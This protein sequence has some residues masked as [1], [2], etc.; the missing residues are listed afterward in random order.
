MWKQNLLHAIAI[1]CAPSGSSPS[2]PSRT[3]S[4]FSSD[5]IVQLA[6]LEDAPAGNFDR[7]LTSVLDDLERVGILFFYNSQNESTQMDTMLVLPMYHRPC[8]T[9]N[10]LQTIRADAA[11]PD[12]VVRLIGLSLTQSLFKD[13]SRLTPFHDGTL[14]RIL[15]ALQ[16]WRKLSASLVELS[17]NRTLEPEFSNEFVKFQWFVSPKLIRILVDAVDRE[18]N[19]KTEGES[20][21]AAVAASDDGVEEELVKTEIERIFSTTHKE[22]KIEDGVDEQAAAN[23]EED[24]LKFDVA[25][26]R[27]AEATTRLLVLIC[28]LEGES[29]AKTMREASIALLWV[30]RRATALPLKEKV[31]C[32]SCILEGH[33]AVVDWVALFFF[34]L[35]SFFFLSLTF[36]FP[37]DW[38]VFFSIKSGRT[39]WSPSQRW[40]QFGAKQSCCSPAEFGT[41]T[42]SIEKTS[43]PST[44][45]FTCCQWQCQC[46]RQRC[47]FRCLP[48]SYCSWPLKYRMG[49]Q[50]N[51]AETNAPCR[52]GRSVQ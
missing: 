16:Q 4:L 44:R 1:V 12:R 33:T 3:R 30:I 11:E 52:D 31:L 37:K 39:L 40:R 6:Q 20:K 15:G 27:P 8:S 49:P 42:K 18:E 47:F 28:D 5:Q 45:S 25:I 36:I 24:E 9:Q 22:V 38:M 7:S 50:I 51:N 34:F 43:P 35:F 21:D 32:P 41:T 29:D 46:K 13:D 26:A 19:S 17:T 14:V 23:D 2:T 10:V 48:I